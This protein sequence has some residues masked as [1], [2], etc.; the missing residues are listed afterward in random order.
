MLGY[1]NYTVWLTY[2]ST[3]L[4]A[5]G[6]GFCIIDPSHSTDYALICLLVCGGLDMFDGKVAR[7]KKDRTDF[8]KDNG[9]QLDSLS[10]LL[11]FGLLP[12]AIGFRLFDNIWRKWYFVFVAV[13]LLVYVLFGLVRL[14]YFNALEH[15]RT[16]TEET[17]L[18][19]YT[20]MPIT[21][22]A[23]FV[24]IVY[25]L[26]F[27]KLPSMVFAWIYL[28]F[29]IV[30]GFLFVLKVKFPKAGKKMIICFSIFGFVFVSA[31]ILLM[32][33]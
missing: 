6:I 28:G 20:G 13:A 25:L 24:P 33:I 11:A 3:L 8:E 17:V 12:A 29:L 10:D 7:T 15:E 27:T 31:F 5:L 16:K 32:F 30:L 4:A 18:K 21:M 19:N 23:F 9:I 2:I 14:A 26:K 1:W 22:A